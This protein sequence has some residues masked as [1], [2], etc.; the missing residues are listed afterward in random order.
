MP[1]GHKPGCNC[2]ICRKIKAKEEAV[3][4]IV[5]TVPKIRPIGQQVITTKQIRANKGLSIP[6][7]TCTTIQGYCQGK[8][9]IEYRKVFAWVTPTD[10]RSRI[11]GGG[12]DNCPH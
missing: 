8:Y 10:I 2:F 4:K 5:E 6:T 9:K 12:L 3:P 1:R 11:V 7:E